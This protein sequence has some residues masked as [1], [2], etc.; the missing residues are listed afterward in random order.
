MKRIV[1]IAGAIAASAAL[2]FSASAWAQEKVTFNMSWLPQGS[3]VGVAV[4]SDQGWFKSAGLDVS[5]IRGY[6]GNRTANELDQGQFEIGYVDRSTADPRSS[7]RELRVS[8]DRRKIRHRRRVAAGRAAELCA[9]DVGGRKDECG[10]ENQALLGAMHG[11][12]Q[13]RTPAPSRC[14]PLRTS[15]EGPIERISGTAGVARGRINDWRYEF[16]ELNEL[17]R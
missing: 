17:N 15:A 3:I 11:V 16:D 5:L 12:L 9:A 14:A 8:R 1:Q 7:E 10:G 2:A 13:K 4:A 6:G